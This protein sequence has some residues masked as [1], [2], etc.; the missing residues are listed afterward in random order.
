M[1]IQPFVINK[2]KER[3]QHKMYR[4]LLHTV[5][6]FYEFINIRTAKYN[7]ELNTLHAF[8]DNKQ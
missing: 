1:P 3:V 2:E 5:M 8:F 4:M 6:V 7:G